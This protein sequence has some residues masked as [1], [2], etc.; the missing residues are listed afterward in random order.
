MIYVS[1]KDEKNMIFDDGYQYG[2]GAFETIAVYK[3]KALF[4][5]EHLERLNKT[6]RFLEIPKVITEHDLEPYLVE[7]TTNYYALKILVSE[8]NIIIKKREI[9]YNKTHYHK[10]FDLE[11]SSIKRNHTSPFV[12]HKT[13]NYGEC[14]LEKR[15]AKEMKL[16]ELIFLNLKNEICE[17]TVCNIFFVKENH[18]FTPKLSCGILPGII[19]NYICQTY[20]VTEVII[21]PSQI[22]DFD[23]CFVTNSLIGIMPVRRIGENFFKKRTRTTKLSKNYVSTIELSTTSI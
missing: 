9:P 3:R 19:R 14:I 7:E 8:K 23:E 6:L 5:N 10:G 21:T 2:I 20:D 22:S 4:L 13:L 15:R 11:F 18:I 17:G 1:R 12:F 16:D